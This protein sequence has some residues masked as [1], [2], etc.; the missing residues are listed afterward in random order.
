VVFAPALFGIG[1]LNAMARSPIETPSV[2]IPLTISAVL[3]IIASIIAAVLIIH[4]SVTA[5][6]RN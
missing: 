6:R 3:F 4:E 1:I 5:W 2:Q